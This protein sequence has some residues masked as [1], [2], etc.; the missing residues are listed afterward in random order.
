MLLVLNCL[1]VILVLSDRKD[2]E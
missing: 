2:A 1:E